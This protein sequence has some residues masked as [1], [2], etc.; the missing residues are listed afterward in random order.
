VTSQQ[1]NLPSLTG[2]ER[3]PLTSDSSNTTE[4][5]FA[6]SERDDDDRFPLPLDYQQLSR[7]SKQVPRYESQEDFIND[8]FKMPDSNS[9]SYSSLLGG[10]ID[11]SIPTPGRVRKTR[12]HPDMYLPPPLNP[13]DEV[14][15]K[16][17]RSDD[18][19]DVNNQLM[20][21]SLSDLEE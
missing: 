6:D 19:Y 18:H 5:N 11:S 2:R 10:E 4:K 14:A 13:A 7:F 17:Y 21:S 1:S 9:R 3:V 16:S 15:N 20:M 12:F 8:D